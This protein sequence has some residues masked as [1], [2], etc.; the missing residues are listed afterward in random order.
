MSSFI[1]KSK[2]LSTAVMLTLVTSLS[3]CNSDDAKEEI[4]EI[5]EE[6]DIV[7]PVITLT[8][9][10]AIS[11]EQGSAY[12]DAGANVTDN[13]DENVTAV[14]GGDTVDTNTV[15]TYT[16]TYNATD[17]AGNQAVEVT[18]VI[19]VTEM[20]D[21]VAPVIALIGEA[22]VTIDQGLTYTDAGAT[23]TDNVDES[24]T[25]VV[26][27]DTVD[28][29]TVG[30]YTITY[31]ATDAAGNQA[32]EI[33]RAVSVVA[34]QQSLSGTAA[35][36]AAIV[37]TVTV[38]D[39]LGATKTVSIEA[40]G[41]Y[42][43][44]VTDMTAPFRLRAEGTV[45]SK[46]YTL[47]SYADEASVDNTVNITPF[48]D[49]IVANAAQQLAS[50]FFDST[51]TTLGAD[52]LA[53]QETALQE[54]LQSVFDALGLEAAIDLMSHSFSADHSGLDAALDL[55]N[56]ETDSAT[57]V[58]TITNLLDGSTIEDNVTDTEDN[59][60]E[61]VFVAEDVVSAGTDTQNIVALFDS[62]SDAFAEG[63]PT[64]ASIEDFFASN[65]LEHDEDLAT[66]LDDLTTDE[67][68][69]GFRFINLSVEELDSTNGTAKVFFIGEQNDYI[70]PRV[71]HW[72]VKK[73]SD[74]NW[75]FTGNQ[76]IVDLEHLSYHCS[77]I[78]ALDPDT[79]SAC[80]INILAVD[81]DSSNNNDAG[82][83]M[84]AKIT[85]LDDK[86][87]IKDSFYLGTPENAS[88][89]AVYNETNKEYDGDW[90]EFGEGAGQIAASNFVTG[91]VVEY[92]FYTENLD[93]TDDAMPVIIGEAVTTYET[94]LAFAPITSPLYPSVQTSIVDDLA[95]FVSGEDLSVSWELAENTKI[96]A[97]KLQ[98]DNSAGD[99]VN[100]IDD[101][102]AANVTQYT[103]PH[104]FLDESWEMATSAD[105]SMGYTLILTVYAMDN[106]TGQEFSVSYS[107]DEAAEDNG[108]VEPPEGGG[109]ETLACGYESG[110]NDELNGGNGGPI[111]PNS[112]ADFKEVVASCGGS[113]VITK[114]DIAGNT[115]VDNDGE[116][117]IYS[118]DGEATMAS[119]S[120]G[121]FSF[122]EDGEVININFK[123]YIETVDN[124]TYIVLYSD[125][126]IDSSLDQ[127]FWF[128]ETRAVVTITGDK[129][130]SGTS[131]DVRMYLE[132]S[133]YSNDDRETE[134]DGEI[135]SNTFTQE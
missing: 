72:Y 129:G 77:D 52:E 124:S 58:A 95:N 134:S 113:S 89:M 6:N 13:V 11:L 102:L 63:A 91:G 71:E 31:N 46:H 128:R 74:S 90:R 73:N 85:I 111:T 2:V 93:L 20:A 45:G 69:A 126:E 70:D 121:Q 103:V 87:I 50:N 3:A 135:T 66:F 130:V 88:E 80:G 32:S 99:F 61:L 83:L 127:G 92:S 23:A 47:H 64:L 81:E 79:G 1:L 59:E 75:Q 43:V 5:I 101:D 35:G 133:D 60:T 16:I 78:D 86:G 106:L 42:E 117:E 30:T 33:T 21:T 22:S 110:W 27:G 39:S 49:L 44:D 8:G 29:N 131:Y 37:G 26:G 7:A 36:G 12:E 119:P 28:T 98:L 57:N 56:I 116:Q 48:T 55:V 15:G 122:D 54:K 62:L 115:W 76:Y 132:Q 112:F 109:G 4:I 67:D 120:S 105:L 18:R 84:S 40:D 94:T 34:V 104:S 38:K 123:W 125:S 9:E 96:A 19:T 10:A 17:A 14:V 25:V 97:V 41:S 24:V 82:P 108:G 65:F 107:H 51:E 68:I 100:E 114:A 53:A 118:T